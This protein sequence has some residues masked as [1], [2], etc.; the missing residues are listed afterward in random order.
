MSSRTQQ[1]LHSSQSMTIIIRTMNLQQVTCLC[2]LD[3]SAAFDTMDHS[4]LLERFRSW[5]GF[6]V[7][8]SCLGLN[9]I[10][11]IDPSMSIL[12]AVNHLFFSFPMV[13][14]R[15]QSR[16]LFFSFY[17]P[18]HSAP[19]F[20]SLLQI[21]IYMQMIPNFICLSQRLNSVKTFLIL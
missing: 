18:L 19:S 12:P 3:L 14:L 2:L 16:D 8:L 21:I 20:L 1:K 17:T 5:F 7:V 9:H 13:Y 10:L 6:N 4:I 11:C 15:D